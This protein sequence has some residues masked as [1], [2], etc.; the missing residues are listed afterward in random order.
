MPVNT[1]IQ[2]I[3]VLLQSN[4][5]HLYTLL[6]ITQR[7]HT[8]PSAPTLNDTDRRP[9]A[10]EPRSRDGRPEDLRIGPLRARVG[11]QIDDRACASRELVRATP[12]RVVETYLLR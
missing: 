9:N 5:S 1:T 6:I 8:V 11:I 2:L 7:P 10:H 3:S 12:A 4:Q